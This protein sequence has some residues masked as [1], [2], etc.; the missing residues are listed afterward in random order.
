MPN[1]WRSCSRAAQAGVSCTDSAATLSWASVNEPEGVGDADW[2]ACARVLI[3]HGVP[4]AVR[5][6]SNPNG[7]LIDGRAMRFSEAVADVLLGIDGGAS[8]ST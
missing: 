1:F 5:D 7:V 3:A 6:P 8:A 4:Q 2:E